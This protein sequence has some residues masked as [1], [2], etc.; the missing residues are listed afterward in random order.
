MD[1][2]RVLELENQEERK[3]EMWMRERIQ[4]KPAKIDGHLRSNMKT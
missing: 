2:G 1:V 4:G 3:R